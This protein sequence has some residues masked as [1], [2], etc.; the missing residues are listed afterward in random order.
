MPVASQ[1]LIPMFSCY[2]VPKSVMHF[3]VNHVK[4]HL[5]SE[6]VG[7]LYKH[8]KIERLLTES[9]SITERRREAINLMHVSNSLFA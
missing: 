8:D 9:D 5:Q 4:E 1:Q 7:Q 3:L 6:L 2:S